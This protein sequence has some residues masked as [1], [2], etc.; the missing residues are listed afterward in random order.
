MLKIKNIMAGGRPPYDKMQIVKDFIEWATDNPEALTVPGFTTTIGINSGMMRAWAA[1]DTEFSALYNIGKEQIGLNRLRESR[2][3]TLDNAIY[4]GHVGNF[5]C[6]INQYMREEKA[7]EASLKNTDPNSKLTNLETLNR[8][9]E[10]L[11]ENAALK[12]EIRKLRENAK[13]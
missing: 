11:R 13:Q 3:G 2:K 5:D 6:D 4:R 1:E 10:M 7:Y 12:E 9:L 8:D